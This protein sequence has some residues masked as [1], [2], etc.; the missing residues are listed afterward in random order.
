MFDYII[1]GA[2]SAGCVLA[3]RLSE[4]PKVKVLLLEAGV[5]D[6][7]RLVSTPG[8]MGLTWR[9]K[10]D[11]TFFTAPQAGLNGRKMHWPRGKTL[12]GSSSINDMIYIRGHRSNYDAWRALGNEGWGYDDVLPYFKRSENNTRGADAFHGSGGPL[13]VCDVEGNPMSDMLVDAAVDALGARRN[14]DFN[15]AEQEGVGRYQATIRGGIRCSTSLA[16]LRPALGRPNLSVRTGVLVAGVEI[17]RGRAV[18]IRYRDGGV[19]EVARASREVILSAGAIGSPH[20]LLLSGVGPAAELKRHG[21]AVAVDLPGVG[22]NLQDHLVIPIS[23]QDRSGVA[24]HVNPLSL[25]AWLARHELTKRGPMASNAAEAGGFL[26]TDGSTSPPDLQ[27]HL[28]PVGTRQV[29]FDQKI[30]MPEGRAFSICPTLL[31][32]KSRGEITLESSDPAQHPR[33]DPRYFEDDAD[34]A[35]LVEGVRVT[36]RMARSSALARARGKSWSPLC[37]VEDERTIR[38]EVRRRVSTIFHPVGTCKMG[39]DDAAVVDPQLRVRGV[40]GLRVVDA[41][42]MP[43]IVGGNTNAPTIMIA[44]KAADILLKSRGGDVGASAAPRA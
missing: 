29:N 23:F 34:L 19:S 42:I 31:Y 44:E 30:F 26:S 10:L 17:E 7:S 5:K 8:L 16:F 35:L 4:D 1:V 20:L 22:K 14:R 28:L 36:Q 24:G 38:E 6:S 43:L 3:A 32:P 2:G 27:L 25:V 21:V 9:T 12:G 33:I 41:S 11:W 37:D 39:V 18:G 40:D 13:D 15:G